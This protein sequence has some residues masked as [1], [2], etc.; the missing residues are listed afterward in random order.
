MQITRSRDCACVLIKVQVSAKIHDGRLTFATTLTLA[1]CSPGLYSLI[2][3]VK[4]LRFN[5]CE[6]N[7]NSQL[8]DHRNYN[9]SYGIVVAD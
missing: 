5:F 3:L 2:A 7:Y 6:L 9:Q 1:T 8:L 4:I